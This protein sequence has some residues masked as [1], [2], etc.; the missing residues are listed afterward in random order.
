MISSAGEYVQ[1]AQPV[2]IS[3]EVENW[4]GEL[5]KVMRIT[6]DQLLKRTVQSG[7]GLDIVNLP[8]QIC[9]L[10][11]MVAFSRNCVNAIQQG[12]L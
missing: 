8:S 6:L 12:K 3:V 1:L 2:Q 7:G 11:E 5:E 10:A 9:C 4:L